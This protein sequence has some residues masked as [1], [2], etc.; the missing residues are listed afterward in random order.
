MRKAL[1][2][3]AVGFI[4]APAVVIAVVSAYLIRE[5]ARASKGRR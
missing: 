2:R 4:T 1:A 3:L 5:D